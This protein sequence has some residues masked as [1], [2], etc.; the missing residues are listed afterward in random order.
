MGLSNWIGQEW[1]TLLQSLGIIGGLF[2]A[3]LSFRDNFK[4]RQVATL[5]D[6]TQSHREIWEKMLF[7]PTLNRV[8]KTAVDLESEPIT[9]D[10]RLIVRFL[11]L[12]LNATYEAGKNSSLARN[13]GFNNDIR[14]FFAAPIP[15]TVWNE[16]RAFQNP[17]FIAFVEGH[18]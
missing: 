7:H 16:L 2:F 1:F 11:V 15:R 18:F 14:H 5:I 12:H 10:E 3:G 6:I 17:A 8:S 4:A 9:E 13:V